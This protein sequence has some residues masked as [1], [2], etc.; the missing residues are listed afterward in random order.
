M[1]EVAKIFH[2]EMAHAIHGYPGKCRHIHGHSYVLHVQVG[3][4]ENTDEQINGTGLILDFSELKKR[5]NECVINGLD[6]KLILSEK[7][8]EAH[9]A[10]ASLENL[11][12]WK[13]EPSAE[14]LLIFIRKQLRDQ[15]PENVSLNG[16]TLY[17]TKDSFAVW[18]KNSNY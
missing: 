11:V 1:L 3:A 13:V 10:L 17:E 4:V 2:F 6:H 16:L 14:N 8:L 5:V 7:F 12:S 15:L 9:P 18:K